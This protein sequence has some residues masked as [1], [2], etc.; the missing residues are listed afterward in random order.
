M[1][2]FIKENFTHDFVPVLA[3]KEI[4]TDDIVINPYGIDKLKDISVL[5]AKE[6]VKSSCYE[7]NFL[8]TKREVQEIIKKKKENLK[9]LLNNI[10]SEKIE[11]M[12]EGKTKEEVYDDLKNLLMYLISNHI[13]TE[14]RRYVSLTSENL[15]KGF[16]QKFVDESIDKF[17]PIFERFIEDKSSE[18]S[19][20]MYSFQNNYYNNHLIENKKSSAQ[21]KNEVKA[22]LIEET[23]KR[24]LLYFFK[25]IIKYICSV[26][27]D[28]FQENS[29]NIYNQIFEKEEF[30]N[31][32]VKLI[33]KDF[34]DIKENLKL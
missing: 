10:I 32:I 31:V 16:A 19:S 7:F 15:I 2:K 29:E 34:E 11:N 28:K 33:E 21:F 9:T 1:E 18:L 20:T 13:Y 23:E 4:I 22:P 30:K 17:N 26:F 5:R 8:K 3:I 27:V 25:N 14:D 24:C 6:A 12:S